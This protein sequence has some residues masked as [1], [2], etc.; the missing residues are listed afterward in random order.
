MYKLP[1]SGFITGLVVALPGLALAQPGVFC[2]GTES[3]GTGVNSCGPPLRYA[4]PVLDAGGIGLTE[5]RIGTC[6][7]NPA[8]Y[9]NVCM[10]ASWTMTIEPEGLSH[11]S[12]KTPHGQ[13]SPTVDGLCTHLIIFSGPMLGAPF[14]FGFDNAK[15]S[16]DVDWDRQS[17]MGSAAANWSEPVGLGLG[18]VHGPR[19]WSIPAVYEWGMVVLVLLL[20]TAVT[21]VVGR[22]RQAASG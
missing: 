18:P 11:Y 1:L 7:G 3:G 21:I 10:P 13:V 15:P 16:H 6:D 17:S 2:D 20:L 22:R 8:N 5:L 9:T 4:Y 14:T 12:G 19:T